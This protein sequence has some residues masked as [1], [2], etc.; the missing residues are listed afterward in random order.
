MLNIKKNKMNISYKIKYIEEFVSSKELAIMM[1]VSTRYLRYVKRG[2][3]SGGG[4][5]ERV[6]SIYTTFKSLEKRSYARRRLSIKEKRKLTSLKKFTTIEIQNKKVSKKGNRITDIEVYFNISF[7]GDKNK[8]K[9]LKTLYKILSGY[10]FSGLFQIYNFKLGDRE[11]NF[12]PLQV[13]D[14]ETFQLQFEENFIAM[15]EMEFYA[16]YREQSSLAVVSKKN[17]VLTKVELRIII[18]I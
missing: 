3:R 11:V 14:L 2:E 13:D 18:Y 10:K 17:I 4:I 16:G 6:N 7:G 5:K 1:D 8:F 12:S 9:V 15:S